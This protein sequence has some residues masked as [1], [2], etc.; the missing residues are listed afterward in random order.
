[1]LPQSYEFYISSFLKILERVNSHKKTTPP[2]LILKDKYGNSYSGSLVSLDIDTKIIVLYSSDEII[3]Y[4]MID[5]LASISLKSVK[6][7]LELLSR[8]NKKISNNTLEDNATLSLDER[9]QMIEAAIIN[10]L[11]IAVKFRF[12]NVNTLDNIE[13]E[14]AISLIDSTFEILLEIATDEF[15]KD[16]VGK[17][18]EFEF[19]NIDSNNFFMLKD[20]NR[21]VLKHCFAQKL[22]NDY[23]SLIKRKLEKLL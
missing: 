17:V 16:L 10:N 2:Q 4:I 14:N 5:N 21:I 9:V 20:S 12:S 1:M 7:N 6:E 13:T 11:G 8:N 22:P 15:G 18:E 3:S 23:H 19:T